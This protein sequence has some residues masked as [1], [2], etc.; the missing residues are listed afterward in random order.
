M[1]RGRFR[2]SRFHHATLRQA[3]ARTPKNR[4]PKRALSELPASEVREAKIEGSGRRQNL[5][6]FQCK[7]FMI[8]DDFGPRQGSDRSGRFSGLPDRALE[9]SRHEPPRREAKTRPSSKD[10][11]DDQSRKRIRLDGGDGEVDPDEEDE[12]EEDDDDD[13]IRK[14]F[15]S[16]ATTRQVHRADNDYCDIAP[17]QKPNRHRS[18]SGSE[19]S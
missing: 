18:R 8:L 13:R 15:V 6:G 4:M 9:T 1:S 12:E 3:D 11:D 7:H 16:S 2:N 5:L 14:Q 10:D 17:H 19:N